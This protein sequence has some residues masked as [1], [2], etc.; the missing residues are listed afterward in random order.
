MFEYGLEYVRAD[1]HLH[2]NK[3]KEFKYIGKQN[4]YIKDYVNALKAANMPPPLLP[5]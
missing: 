3:D 4:D 1:F 5:T 2:T